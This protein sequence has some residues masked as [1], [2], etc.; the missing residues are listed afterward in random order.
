MSSSVVPVQL[1]WYEPGQLYCKG[2]IGNSDEGRFCCKLDA[3][4]TF[5]SHK[6][7]Q[8]TLVEG[9]LYIRSV[10][11]QFQAKCKPS[12][13]PEWLSGGAE[14]VQKLLEQSN[15]VGTWAT[16]FWA[17]RHQINQSVDSP[18]M[19]MK[20]DGKTV[21]G[22]SKKRL[23]DSD[24]LDLSIY[25]RAVEDFYTP[26]WIKLGASLN[27]LDDDADDTLMSEEYHNISRLG[28][29]E[30][31]AEMDAMKMKGYLFDIFNN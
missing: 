1:F 11:N 13:D 27:V 30:D 24:V 12:L 23:T 3:D 9:H 7:K 8:A 14:Q 17:C 19:P 2:M 4:C 22:L 25:K 6:A 21:Q 10:K 20:S 18:S 26:K 16:Y 15:P 28:S 31:I 29:T 5:K